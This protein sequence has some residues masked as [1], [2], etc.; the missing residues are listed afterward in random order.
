MRDHADNCVVVICS[1]KALDAMR[2]RTGDSIT[3]RRPPRRSPTSS[4]SA[5]ATPRARASAASSADTGGSSIQFAVEP[6]E[7]RRRRHRDEPARVAQQRGAREQGHWVPDRRDRAARLAV[8]VPATRRDR[9][10]HHRRDAGVVRAGHRLRGHQGAAMGVREAAR[11]ERR[12][13]SLGTMMQSV[14]EVM[15]IGRTF[16]ESFQKA[17]RSLES[18]RWGLNCDPT[19]R[20]VRRTSYR[21]A[22]SPRGRARRRRRPFWLDAALRRGVTVERLSEATGIDP[23]SCSTS[24]IA[25][26]PA[27]GHQPGS[28]PDELVGARGGK[29]QAHGVAQPR[30]SRT[31]WDV[32]EAGGLR[33]TGR[34]GASS[35]RS[36]RLTPAPPRVPRRARRYHYGTYEDEDEVAPLIAVRPS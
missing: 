13:G 7:R 32:A 24:A 26:R 20:R 17:L 15:A 8:G 30:C 31:C 12:A 6:G 23:G 18:G 35:S 10:R 11:L 27:P 3:G 4:T 36:R 33:R 28:W 25:G 2:V 29:R 9:E 19:E 1:I 22:G 5:C 16:A 21:R 14:G 34:G